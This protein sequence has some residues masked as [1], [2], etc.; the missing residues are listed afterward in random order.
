LKAVRLFVAVPLP[1]RL[2]S[3][4]QTVAVAVPGLREIPRENLHVTVHFL[5]PVDPDLV[6]PLTAALTAACAG[7]EPFELRFEAVV[8]APSRRPRMLWARAAASP[9]HAAL[10]HAVAAAAGDATPAAGAPRASSPHVTMARARGRGE[11]V[12]WPH[13]ETLEDARLHVSGCVLMRSDP[14]PGGSRY[15]VLQ[16]FELG[17]AQPARRR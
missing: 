8:P 2:A 17:G 16:R 15:T 6:A 4:L 5:G 3:Q 10:A 13:P 12:R 7:V 9:H 14:G 11:R 1:D